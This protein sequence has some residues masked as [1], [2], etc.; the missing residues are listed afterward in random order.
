[1]TVQSVA[2]SLARILCELCAFLVGF[3]VRGFNHRGR[4]ETTKN[5][6]KKKRK[7]TKISKI[8]SQITNKFQISITSDQNPATSNKS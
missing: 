8:K 5:T 3:V 6:K 7:K 1:M 2:A 4:K